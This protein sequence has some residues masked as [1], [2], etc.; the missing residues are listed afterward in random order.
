MSL[1]AKLNLKEFNAEMNRL[2]KKKAKKSLYIKKENVLKNV[3]LLY[4]KIT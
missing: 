4:K 1:K 3:W 2:Q